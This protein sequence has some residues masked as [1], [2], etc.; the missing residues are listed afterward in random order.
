MVRPSDPLFLNGIGIRNRIVLP[1][2]T[3]NYGTADGCVTEDVLGFYKQRARHVGMVIVEAA[4]V[5]A[6]GR[7]VPRGLGLWSRSHLP[8]LA[9][10]AEAIK[11]KG[12]I[13]TVQINHGGARCFPLGGAMQ[14]ASPSGVPLRTDVVPFEMGQGQ[15]DQIIEDFACA[16]A[17][18]CEAG[19]DGVEIHGA[20]FYLVSQFLSP[21]TNIRE[22]RYGGD[23]ASRATFAAEVVRAVRDRV[24]M[25]ALLLFRMNAVERVDGGQSL[26]DALLVARELVRSGVNVI[27]VS[28][29]AQAS[30][31]EERGRRFLATCSAFPKDKLPGAGVPLAA[32]I[33]K[34]SGLPVI[35]VGKLGHPEAAVRALKEGS[36]DMVAIGRQMIADPD[37]AGKILTGQ[38]ADIV[39]CKECMKCFG[40]IARGLPMGCAVTE[41]PAGMAYRAAY[42]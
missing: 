29:A 33:K 32:A 9:R 21:L 1:P 39:S 16:S 4:A 26:E 35:A 17:L 41:N 20:H 28:L 10:L 34:I 12:A 8:G 18:G 14:G 6:D 40:M 3:T 36:T 5:R 42:Q 19:F 23:A 30:W 22:D 38:D 2:M 25:K 11:A 7:L 37:T 24:G 31:C 27:D 13:A 15:I